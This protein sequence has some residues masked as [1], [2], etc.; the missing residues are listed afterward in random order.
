[1]YG[2]VT[3]SKEQRL[4]LFNCRANVIVSFKKSMW[5][6]RSGL[7]FGSSQLF[8]RVLLSALFL[9]RDF[10]SRS[11]HIFNPFTVTL[12]LTQFS[13]HSTAFPPLVMLCW[14]ISATD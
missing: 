11:S 5:V 3:I 1:M 14:K 10:L 6:E 2:T 4:Y 7:N 8:L 9:L 12:P 13:T